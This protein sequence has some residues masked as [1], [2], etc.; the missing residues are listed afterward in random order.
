MNAKTLVLSMSVD[1]EPA[2]QGFRLPFVDRQKN[3]E[4]TVSGLFFG[5]RS[6]VV[7]VFDCRQPWCVVAC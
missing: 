6:V 3:G 2:G 7:G 1:G 4:N 5:P